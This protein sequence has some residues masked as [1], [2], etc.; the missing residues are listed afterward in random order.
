MKVGLIG[1]G[2]A[3][4][5]V[6]AVLLRHKD[7]C[8]EWVVRDS[9]RLEHRSVPEFLGV[10]SREP[11]YIFS[12]QNTS[13]R[14]L[15]ET[16]PVDFVIDFSGPESLADY[17]PLA[18]DRRIGIVS[19][20]SHYPEQALELL[21]QLALK[22]RVFWSP[23]ITLGVNYMLKAAEFL[24]RIAPETDFAIVEEHFKEKAGISG[25]ARIIAERLNIPE[26]QVHSV[27]AGGII[28]RHEIICGFPFQT[29]R[30]IHESITREAFGNGVIF[31]CQNLKDK[32]PGLYN[33]DLLL[34]RY[35]QFTGQN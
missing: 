7:L 35:F 5:A 25:T 23:N 14:E 21:N 32:G 17:G 29:V 28:G 33:F 18:A 24:Q 26:T 16:Q 15:F 19:A 13:F 27:R 20:V 4:K 1:F 10:E 22:T 11:G 12:R 9:L 8:L 2:R 6:A 30:F 31:V 34:D 3:G